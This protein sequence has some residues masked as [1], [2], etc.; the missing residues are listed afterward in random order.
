MIRWLENTLP[1]GK[2]S[3]AFV[4]TDALQDALELK[5]KLED[6]FLPKESFITEMSPVVGA[7]TGPGLVG[8]AW[9]VNPI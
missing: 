5:R 7:H 4:H 6:L 2:V 1:K 3:L 8:A 9:W